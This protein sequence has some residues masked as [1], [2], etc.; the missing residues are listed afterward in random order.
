WKSLC[1]NTIRSSFHC[2][3]TFRSSSD[4]EVGSLKF[5]RLDDQKLLAWLCCKVKNMSKVLP[6]LNKLYSGR[7]EEQTMLDAVGLL[8]EYLKEDPWLCFLCNRLGLD[9]EATKKPQI[10]N[11]EFVELTS[12]TIP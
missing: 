9:V 5:Y 1:R 2:F 3:A 7:T 11:S 8:A 10:K 12:E 4:E 6:T